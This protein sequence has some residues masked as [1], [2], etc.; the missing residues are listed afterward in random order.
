[1]QGEILSSHMALWHVY[2]SRAMGG[3]ATLTAC[4]IFPRVFVHSVLKVSDLPF[5]AIFIS[6]NAQ[7]SSLILPTQNCDRPFHGIYKISFL[8]PEKENERTHES[9]CSHLL[10]DIGLVSHLVSTSLNACTSFKNSMPSNPLFSLI[11]PYPGTEDVVS[12][13]SSPFL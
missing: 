7:K 2:L 9:W 6:C 5:F 12:L 8:I 4:K 13:S 10:E 11:S 3:M 1:M